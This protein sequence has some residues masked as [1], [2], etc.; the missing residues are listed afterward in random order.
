MNLKNQCRAI[1]A[2]SLLAFTALSS[3]PAQAEHKFKI[4]FSQSYIG[5]N[6]LNEAVNMVKAMAASSTY[7]DKVDLQVQISGADVQKQIQQ[8]NAMIQAGADAI[9]LYPVSET[10]LNQ[11]IRR[12][13]DK[14]IKI[15][16]YDG[17]VS[18]PCAY[19]LHI[20]QDEA[21]RG[22]AQWLVKQLNGR[23]NIV[24]ITGIAGTSVDTKRKG[25][26]MEVFSKHPDI[27]VIAEA[28]GQWTQ[29]GAR[30]EL[31]KILAT[32]PWSEINGIWLETGCYTVASMQDEAGIHDDKKI[33]CAGEG[34]N[35]HL[36]QMLPPGTAV[37]GAN[38]TY[39]PMGYPSVSYDAKPYGGALAFKHAV[40]VLEGK[41]IPKDMKLPLPFLTNSDI[42]LCKTGTW[43]EW[44]KTGCNTFAPAQVP[45]PTWFPE[46]FHADLPEIGLKAALNG[47]PEF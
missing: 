33:P 5:N 28:N 15:F 6:W 35:G 36:L 11:V 42:I 38:G 32:H 46:I 22:D 1:A 41:D 7:K 43:E 29:S 17:E 25:A 20:D 31:T 30:N 13:C 12:A 16:A 27:H 23:G 4:Y 8:L 10:A 14:G 2:A 47:T 3:Q 24:V 26:A 44:K 37:D 40:E 39:R 9:V 19:N 34:V 45:D 21:G 18:E